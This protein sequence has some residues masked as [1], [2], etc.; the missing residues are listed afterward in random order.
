MKKKV[1]GLVL[2][3]AVLVTTVN[4]PAAAAEEGADASGVI[5]KVADNGNGSDAE[6]SGGIQTVQV[7]AQNQGQTVC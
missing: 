2:V 7:S 6:E 4:F 5:V 1:W 3:F